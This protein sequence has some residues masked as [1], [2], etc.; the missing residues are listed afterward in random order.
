[1]PIFRVK[2]VKLYTG[3]KK[4]TRTCSWGSWQISGMNSISVCNLWTLADMIR[5]DIVNEKYVDYSL[6]GRSLCKKNFLVF[7]CLIIKHALQWHIAKCFGFHVP[8]CVCGKYWLV[9]LDKMWNLNSVFGV[10][11]SPPYTVL[12]ITTAP[13]TEEPQ[14]T[15][16]GWGT[17]PRCCVHGKENC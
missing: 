6:S 13:T 4:F 9:R 16:S 3:Q 17:S 7:L 8:W 5:K 2:S 12:S 1:M 11:G 14:T 15:P 10:R